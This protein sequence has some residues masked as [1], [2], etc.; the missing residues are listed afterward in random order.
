MQMLAY[1]IAVDCN[2]YLKIGANTALECMKKFALGIIDIF[3]DE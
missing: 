1:G 2:E 3:E